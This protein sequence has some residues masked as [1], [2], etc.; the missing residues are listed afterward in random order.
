MRLFIRRLKKRKEKIGNKN[1]FYIVRL[2]GLRRKL[3]EEC[4]LKYG[5]RVF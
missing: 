5:N 3:R 1:F 2:E 4:V